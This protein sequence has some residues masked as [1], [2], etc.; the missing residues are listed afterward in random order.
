MLEVLLRT[1]A[2]VGRPLFDS[3]QTL[4]TPHLIDGDA[5]RI[6]FR[7]TATRELDADRGRLGLPIWPIL[8]SAGTHTIDFYGVS[9]NC[10]TILPPIVLYAP[11]SR[12]ARRAATYQRPAPAGGHPRVEFV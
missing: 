1:L 12:S 10:A 3:R 5:A 7:N 9:G 11:P 8:P 2:A 6:I 4:Q